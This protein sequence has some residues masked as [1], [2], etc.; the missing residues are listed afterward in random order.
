MRRIRHTIHHCRQYGHAPIIS[1]M[2]GEAKRY[3]QEIN[4]IQKK[5][6]PGQFMAY[7][8][9]LPDLSP[10]CLASPPTGSGHPTRRIASHLFFLVFSSPRK[11][12]FFLLY[13]FLSSFVSSLSELSLPIRVTLYPWLSGTLNSFRIPLGRSLISSRI[14][15]IR[16]YPGPILGIVFLLFL[17]TTSPPPVYGYAFSPLSVTDIFTAFSCIICSC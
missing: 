5:V 6:Y 16:G 9:I 7:R 3:R 11:T 13:C 14:V 8:N 10:R 2:A 4:Y 1:E 15:P 17:F 12:F